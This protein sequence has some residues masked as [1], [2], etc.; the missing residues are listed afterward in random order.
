VKRAKKKNLGLIEVVSAQEA[1]SEQSDLV[2][3]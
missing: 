1:E 2:L 3:P